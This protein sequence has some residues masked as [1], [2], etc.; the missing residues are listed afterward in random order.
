MSPF[1]FFTTLGLSLLLMVIVIWLGI[2]NDE[3]N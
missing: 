1:T 2:V 3:D